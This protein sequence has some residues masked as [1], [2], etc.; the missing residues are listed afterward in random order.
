MFRASVQ[1]FAQDPRIL[2]WDLWNE[3]DNDNASTYGP[4]ELRNKKDVVTALLPQVF[5]W[6]RAS[7]PTQ[8]LTSGIWGDW[9]SL[10]E[11]PPIAHVQ[12]EQSDVISFPHLQLARAVRSSYSSARAVPSSTPLYRI[13][14][15]RSWQHLRHD[16]ADSPNSSRLGAINW[17]L[18]AGKTQTY[19]PWD[20]WQHPY[21][22][23]KPP[24]WFHDVFHEDGTLYRK[25]EGTIMRNLT[26]AP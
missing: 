10:D 16:S 13:H 9:T 14:G 12:L 15:A 24:V 6:A 2:A 18:V 19:L 5:A 8:P 17:G 20:S 23:E 1:T 3:P 26:G 21:V 22:I 25:R 11:L 4:V 7:H